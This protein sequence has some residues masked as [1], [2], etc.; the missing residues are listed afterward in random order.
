M[1][2]FQKTYESIE[3]VE[4]YIGQKNLQ[5]SEQTIL[6]KFYSQIQDSV[7]LDVGIGAGRT[8]YH[9][10][11]IAKKY[12]GID[13]SSAMINGAKNNFKNLNIDFQVCD[14]RNMKVFEDAMF[15][16]IFFSFNGI[17]YIDEDGRDLFFKEVKRISKK[18][19]LLIFSTHNILNLPNLF[20]FKFSYH[21]RELCY[22][23]IKYLKLRNFNKNTLVNLKDKNVIK[24][25]DGAHDFCL[26]T[27]Y[28]LP[29]YQVK[30]LEKMGFTNVNC[31]DYYSGNLISKV[32]VSTITDPWI[33]Y[34]CNV[35][36]G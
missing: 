32:D 5:K 11:A 15:D 4:E 9:L 12:V 21:P 18:N 19:A 28:I 17:D 26:E 23:L 3:V 24:I 30:E 10:S 20:S 2:A 35:N 36:N 25:N 13:I 1:E 14:A 29:E 33:Y 34:S 31:F 7:L 16:V 27:I 6:K 8:T 22:N